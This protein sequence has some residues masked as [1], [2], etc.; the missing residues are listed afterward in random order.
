MPDMDSSSGRSKVGPKQTDRLEG[1][2]R[3][4]SDFSA[5]LFQQEKQKEKIQSEVII[6]WS[7]TLKRKQ[8]MTK[9]GYR[10][11]HS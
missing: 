5:T 2:I 7:K 8:N 6:S 1:I 4:L 3:F 10:E 9:K 11:K